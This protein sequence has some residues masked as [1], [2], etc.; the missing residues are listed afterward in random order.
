MKIRCLSPMSI[1]IYTFLTL[2]TPR[3]KLSRYSI[4]FSQFIRSKMEA[5]WCIGNA[6]SVDSWHS[7]KVWNILESSK[8]RMFAN[9]RALGIYLTF[10]GDEIKDIED[11]INYLVR[12]IFALGLLVS[13]NFEWRTW[14]TPPPP[15]PRFLV[16][17]WEL[18]CEEISRQKLVFP[19][20][21][22]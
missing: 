8:R 7:V 14:Q 19:M 20:I 17:L 4:I 13:F 11:S 6:Q 12:P 9:L 21:V 15:P 22:S 18:T 2:G 16:I 1:C 10:L 3:I 5:N